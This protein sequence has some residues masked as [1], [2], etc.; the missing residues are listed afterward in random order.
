MAIDAIFYGGL[1]LHGVFGR[2][3]A[4]HAFCHKYFGIVLRNMRVVAGAA[5]HLAPGKTFA[6]LKQLHLFSMHI[7]IGLA[8][9]KMRKIIIGQRIPG[10][11][12]KQGA[13]YIEVVS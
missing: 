5:G 13:L 2:L 6:L 11:K 10:L 9:A 4:T 7:R 3:V 12:S 1:L 8:L